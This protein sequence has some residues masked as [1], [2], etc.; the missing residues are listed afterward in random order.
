MITL[1]RLKEVLTYNPEN[2]LFT[3]I[4]S[5]NKKIIVGSI[6]GGIDEKSYLRIKID[7]KKYRTNNYFLI[8]RNN[9]SK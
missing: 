7:G 6:A 8:S 2:G 1:E 9:P 4:I 3:W 5:T